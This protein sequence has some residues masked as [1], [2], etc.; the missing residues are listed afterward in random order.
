MTK[1]LSSVRV[2]AGE[3][4][5]R[6]IIFPHNLMIR[7]TGDRIRE[8]LFSWLQT[9]IAGANCLDL[10]AGS[11]ALGI[12]ALSRGAKKATFVEINKKAALALNENLQSFGTRNATVH[13]IDAFDWLRKNRF[14]DRFSIVFL[15]P[16]FTKDILPS[17][18]RLLEK[19]NILT[20]ECKIYI[21]SGKAIEKS[22][23]PPTW[24]VVKNKKAGSV[25]YC[26]CQRISH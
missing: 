7:P 24:D 11:G 3:F 21:E 26:L 8:S 13:E 6:K 20:S 5:S 9:E 4:K 22:D 10:F 14:E 12:E 16:P 18:Y 25:H 15:D 17:C 19:A 2:I 1:K 23:I